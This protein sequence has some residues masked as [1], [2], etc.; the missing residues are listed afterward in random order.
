MAASELESLEK[1]NRQPGA[2]LQDGKKKR[3]EKR[4]VKEDFISAT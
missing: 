3:K 4:F 2:R 1:G